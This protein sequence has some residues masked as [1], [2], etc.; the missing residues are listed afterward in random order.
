LL[1][2]KRQLAQAACSIDTIFVY[3]YHCGSV[4]GACSLYKVNNELMCSLLSFLEIYVLTKLFFLSLCV[5][6]VVLVKLSEI[7]DGCHGN[8][9]CILILN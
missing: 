9:I 5:V 7:M 3:N 2:T 4:S 6:L 1:K 8:N